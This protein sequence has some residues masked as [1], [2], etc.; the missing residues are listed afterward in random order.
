MILCQDNQHSFK[1]FYYTLGVCREAEENYM[2]RIDE[3]ITAEYSRGTAANNP[4]RGGM[5]N[6]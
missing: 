6:L 5:T 2:D 4:E 3:R 1:Q